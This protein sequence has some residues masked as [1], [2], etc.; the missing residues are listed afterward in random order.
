MSI[1]IHELAKELHMENKELIALLKDRVAQGCQFII[2]T[3]S[4]MLM[5][6][7]QAAIHVFANGTIQLTP[8][9]EVEH[10][11]LMK[12]FLADPQRFLRHL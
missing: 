2:A 7:P 8:Y 3:H 6:F 5:A 4:P 9:A 11:S 12:S 1:R 10:V